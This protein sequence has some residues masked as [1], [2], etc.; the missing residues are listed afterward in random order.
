MKKYLLAL[1][2]SAAALWP[3]LAVDSFSSMGDSNFVADVNT[4]R[5]VTQV[6]FT[7]PR[8]ISLP[9]ADATQIGQGGAANDY[10]QTL[11]FFDS[12]GTVG[13]SNTLTIIPQGT[14]TI[15]G[16][17]S[18]VVIDYANS[19]V[20]MYPLS[21]SNWFLTQQGQAV[22]VG[23]AGGDLS[24]TYPNPTVAKVNGNTIPASIAAHQ[25][26]IGTAAS[27]I[28]YRTLP[29]CP[30]TT[31]KH[32]NYAQSGDVFTC[33]TSGIIASLVVGTTTITSGANT[34]ILYN[35]GG[36]LGEYALATL[37]DMYAAS[38]ANKVVTPS[39][40]YP[41]ETTTTYGTTTTFDF[42][43]FKTTKVT[44]T[45]NI[46]T[47]TLSNVTVGKAGT[48]TF[49]QDGTGS[50]T[51]VWNSIFKFSGGITPTLTTTA[52]AVDML[53]F[54]CR[55]ATFCAASLLPDVK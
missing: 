27:T 50:R 21:G 9:H 2:L 14:D 12:L 11:E 8:S 51:T 55:T 37:A 18:S 45:G 17:H 32:L 49:I 47:Q 22:L 15:N 52:D 26:P 29:D 3:A 44:L 20:I 34:A 41:T 10:A 19:H 36:V 46:T 48:I 7:A 4:V 53:S 35:N 1:F 39:V 31:G 24:G 6:A 42:S 43:T 30:D 5:I 54:V 28:S 38:A 25:V 33:G 23:P 40:L 16:S 13:I